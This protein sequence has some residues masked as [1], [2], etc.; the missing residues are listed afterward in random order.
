MRLNYRIFDNLLTRPKNRQDIDGY[1]KVQ[2]VLKESI[3][4]PLRTYNFVRADKT[5]EL[6][7]LLENLPAA[8]SMLN[9]E[10]GIDLMLT[11]ST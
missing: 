4:N 2:K 3:V 1:A 5:M 8:K 7:E 10:Q 6:R 11:Y 9:D